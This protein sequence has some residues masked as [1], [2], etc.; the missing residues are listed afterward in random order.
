[1]GITNGSVD[2]TLTRVLDVY[3]I[4]ILCI[5]M[6]LIIIPYNLDQIEWHGH[7][8]YFPIYLWM[9]NYRPLQL[10]VHIIPK[11]S[12]KGTK[13]TTISIWDDASW[14]PK[15]NLNHF[16]NNFASF[17]P[18]MVFEQAMKLQILLNLPTTYQ[19]P[20]IDS[21]VPSWFLEYYTQNPWICYPMV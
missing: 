17:C 3:Q 12:P 7:H 19:L 21:H 1:M 2:Y 11:C 10:S 4:L 13:K 20:E 6:L 14:Y 15:V 8:L 18:F 5:W 16:K 9:E